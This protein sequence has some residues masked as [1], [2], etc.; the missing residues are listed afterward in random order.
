MAFDFSRMLAACEELQAALDTMDDGEILAIPSI[1]DLRDAL[2]TAAAPIERALFLKRFTAL[3]SRMEQ[4]RQ[5]AIKKMG[6]IPTALFE[7]EI[8]LA[9]CDFQEEHYQWQAY[10]S[11]RLFDSLL[12]DVWE[13]RKC[14]FI[15]DWNVRNAMRR[16]F[17][18]DFFHM[19]EEK[20]LC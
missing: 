17:L 18:A 7:D 12:E 20:A 1:V 16:P 10:S 6:K 14:G 13:S 9:L 19:E 3:C 5:D 4:A 11:D 8:F 2:F 15:F